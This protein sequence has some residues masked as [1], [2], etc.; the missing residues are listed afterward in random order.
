MIT[1]EI[2]LTIG[3]QYQAIFGENPEADKLSTTG[4][5]LYVMFSLIVNI[6]ALNL[7]IAILSDTF[8]NV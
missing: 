5:I 6:I 2:G 4:W 7:L 8:E 1:G 3:Q